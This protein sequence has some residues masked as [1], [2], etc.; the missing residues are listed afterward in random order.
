MTRK[1]SRPSR[2]KKDALQVVH[3][4]AAAIDIGSRFHVVAIPPDHD[5]LPVRVGSRVIN[6]PLG[7]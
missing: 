5:E 2:S 7:K 1:A 6:Y 4:H 3:P